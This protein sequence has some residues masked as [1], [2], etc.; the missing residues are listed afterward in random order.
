MAATL[1]Q[2]Q[3]AAEVRRQGG[4][5][6]Q[7]ARAAGVS[8]STVKRWWKDPAFRAMVNSSPDIR[9]GLPP[10]EAQS[11]ERVSP[12]GVRSRMW[13][14]A[15]SDGSGEVLGTFIPPAADEAGDAVLHV[16]VVPAEAVEAVR[17]SI[18]AQEYPAESPYVPVLLA[19]LHELVENLPLVCR[20][21]SADQRE[22]LSAWLEVWTFV[23]EEGCTRTLAASLWPGQAHFL[24]A[25]IGNGHVVSI[26][27]RKVG[28]STL[29][30]AY[31]AWTAR[32]R[33]VNASVHLLSHREDAAKELLRALQRGFTGLPA[34]LRLPLERGTST[35]LAFAAGPSDTRSLKA[36]PATPNASIETTCS[37]LVLDEWAHTFDPEA[38]WSA[39]EPT[40]APRATSALIT[41][42]GGPG[43]F[44]HSYYQRSQLGETRHT[45]VF[46]SALERPDRSPAWL[47][48]KRVHEGK[49]GSLRNYPTSVEEAFSAAGEPY[50]D[51]EL[52]IAAQRDAFASSPVRRGDRCL[53]AWD[54][55]K[56]RS[57]CVVLQ[58]AAEDEPDVWHV[59][60]YRRLVDEDYPTIQ[61]EIEK[62][63]RKYPG[64]TV[65][66]ANGPGNPVIDFL[67]LP[68]GELIK[69]TAT[70]ASKQQMLTAIELRLQQGTLKIPTEFEQLLVEL[71][72]YRDPE[73]SIVQDSVMALG[74]A[75]ANAGLAQAGSPIRESV[76][77]LEPFTD[78]WYDWY[79][80][81]RLRSEKDLWNDND[82]RRGII[83]PAERK[84][85]ERASRRSLVT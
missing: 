25:L 32:I 15:G 30:C 28:L 5:H 37:H 34:F 33:D 6:E 69:F 19:G 11:T 79:A 71:G 83:P 50:F 51:A 60:A 17:A 22:S 85:R 31:A 2:R 56:K 70:K 74:I 73:G 18:G 38:I 57:V 36:F 58:V 81:R 14:T 67:H 41:T 61:R 78:E 49:W 80:V 48:Q 1:R 62:V 65:V 20:L 27:A 21:G 13:V 7:A 77:D 10:L 8:V 75:V 39:V 4:T 45:P 84:A 12:G 53:K 63:H 16:H 52:L 23:D 44:V 82:A 3:K 35:V 9:P 47:E 64:P 40:L 42:A 72:D 43:D 24:E 29:V 55:G 59:R 76:L 68:E 66:E 54:I 46:V 26:K